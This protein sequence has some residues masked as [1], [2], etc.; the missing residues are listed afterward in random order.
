MGRRAG[1][2]FDVRLFTLCG[3]D[4]GGNEVDGSWR[5]LVFLCQ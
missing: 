3:M 5:G 1:G 4:S 2:G